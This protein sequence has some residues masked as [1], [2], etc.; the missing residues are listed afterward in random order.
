MDG[1][2]VK[3]EADPDRTMQEALATALSSPAVLSAIARGHADHFNGMLLGL[4]NLAQ[5]LQHQREG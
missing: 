1:Q 4:L 5:S 3:Q 2:D